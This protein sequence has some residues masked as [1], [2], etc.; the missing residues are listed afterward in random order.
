MRTLNPEIIGQKE[1]YG[2]LYNAMQGD[3]IGEIMRQY[4]GS[5]FE[6]IFHGEMKGH[7]L[8]VL[9]NILPN[10]YEMCQDVKTALGFDEPIDFYI[11]GSADINASAILSTDS[12]KPHV[13][14]INSALF[15]L[16]SDDE[17]RFIL[18]HEIGHLINRDGL[19]KEIY[20]YIYPD[21]DDEEKTIPRFLESRYELWGRLAE[22]SADRYGY[23][24]CENIEAC[25]TAMYKLNSGLLL[26][27]MN[28]RMP[29]LLEHNS[30]S[31]EYYLNEHISFGGTHP[32]N[33]ARI[34]ALHLFATAKTQKALNEGMD[35]LMEVVEGVYYN[36]LE[37]NIATFFGCAGLYMCK[38]RGKAAKQEEE[39]IIERMAGFAF[40]PA[41]LYKHLSKDDYMGLMHQSLD[42][43]LEIDPGALNLLV[44]YL[45]DLAFVD[46]RI[47]EDELN[48]IFAIAEQLEINPALLYRALTE[49]IRLDFHP[50][51]ALM[52]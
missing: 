40:R 43:I 3:I 19:L 31:L 30:L 13:I 8:Q 38:E 17:L 18:G 6:R 45:I 16:M 12:S 23:I 22:F 33:P 48:K 15:N 4:K 44:S 27:K 46:N 10:L 34:Q 47:E 36:E 39:F 20:C 5:D 11:T 37:D 35:T 24:A 14:D 9:P 28:I 1:L 7:S 32:I 41:K 26:D 25:V 52:D 51:A 49:K 2:Q 50:V 29:D 42:R 21:M